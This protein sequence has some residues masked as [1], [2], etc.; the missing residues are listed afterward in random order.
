[1]AADQYVLG[2]PGMAELRVRNESV[3]LAD[4]VQEI[5]SSPPAATRRPGRQSGR[6]HGK[7][8]GNARRRDIARAGSERFAGTHR[9]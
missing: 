3:D 4:A 2:Q 6:R 1:M 5:S 8:T 7:A 9:P